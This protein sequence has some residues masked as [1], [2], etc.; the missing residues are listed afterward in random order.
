MRVFILDA[1][2]LPIKIR[3]WN[4]HNGLIVWAYLKSVN[5]TAIKPFSVLI[6]FYIFF[7]IYFK[8][9]LKTKDRKMKIYMWH[10]AIEAY[11]ILSLWRL[12]TFMHG[13]CVC[14]LSDLNCENSLHCH[15]WGEK[16]MW[17]N[18]VATPSGR[19]KSIYIYKRAV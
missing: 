15:L 18:T 14:W 9:N 6:Y 4:S 13:F 7:Y 17:K 16:N 10:N 12:K 19:K 11:V 1:V 5:M 8:G 2:Y 3:Y